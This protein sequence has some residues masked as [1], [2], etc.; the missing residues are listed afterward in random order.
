M[1]VLMHSCKPDMLIKKIP[2]YSKETTSPNYIFV[3][4]NLLIRIVNMGCLTNGF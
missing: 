4:F 2:F 1:K 3:S